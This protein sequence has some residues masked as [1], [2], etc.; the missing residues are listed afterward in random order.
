MKENEI[1]VS[2]I[3]SDSSGCVSARVRTLETDRT[4]WFQLP[5]SHRPH[6][7]SIAT[8]IA[9]VFG[10]G[11]DNWTYL[12]PISTEALS[13]LEAVTAADWDAPLYS[14]MAREP[15]PNTILSF[16]GGFDSMAAL[17]LLGE[18]TPLV[19]VDFGS[20]FQRERAFFEQFD[21]A[22]VET[23]ARDFEQSWTFMGSAA[24]LMADYFDGGYLSFG[25]I[26]EASPWGML[27][28][29]TPRIG[30]PVFRASGLDE[31][32]PLAGMT[33]FA[34]ARLAA[35]AYPGLIAESLLSLADL[36]TEKYMR[37]YL[38]LQ[39][40]K[41]NLNDL[42]LGDIPKPSMTSP[43]RFGS[44]FAADFLAP[45]LWTHNENSSRWMEIPL[46]FNTWR[47]GKDFNFYWSEL[48]NQTFHPRETDNQ[49]ISKRKSLYGIKPY[50]AIDWDNFRS[51][52]E[53]IK[54]FHQLPGKSW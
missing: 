26:L 52:L 16:S 50:D 18:S 51:V 43:I 10:T 13:Q 41:E 32:N 53:I 30:H 4:I 29:R 24:I 15:G 23:N 8:A 47:V 34:T 21:T 44:N 42:N 46:G 11:Y 48:P 35:M 25:S 31:T 7:D 20:R 3:E 2:E 14:V 12:G 19:S 40:V 54:F 9:S 45:G 33:E 17:A 27:E 36:H 5:D 37:K 49:E 38:M 28:R 39:I 1:V 22:I 6:P